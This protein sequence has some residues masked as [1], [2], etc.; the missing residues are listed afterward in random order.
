MTTTPGVRPSDDV[1]TIDLVNQINQQN[2]SNVRPNI[3]TNTSVS[4]YSI[5]LNTTSLNINLNG[6]VAYL[7][8]NRSWIET[9]V[10]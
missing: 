4:L 3:T 8:G 7:L 5:D 1:L 10:D 6:S 9:S 2:G